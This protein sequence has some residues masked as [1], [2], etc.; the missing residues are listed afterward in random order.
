MKG[1]LFLM[2]ENR[3]AFVEEVVADLKEQNLYNTIRTIQSP[4]GAWVTIEGRKVLNMCSNNYLG[5]ANHPA[6]CAAAKKAI[7]DYGVGP[8]AVR[9]LL[10]PSSA[11]KQHSLCNLVSWLTWR[12]SRL[13]LARV[14]PL[15]LMN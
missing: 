14:I 8:G 1:E 10:Q 4:Q 9:K 11:W 15:F 13:W 6:L 7:D 2:T 12:L 3:L 5:L